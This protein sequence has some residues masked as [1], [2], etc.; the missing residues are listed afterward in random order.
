MFI[1]TVL[2][3]QWNSTYMK[4]LLVCMPGQKQMDKTSLDNWI[5]KIGWPLFHK[6]SYR[7]SEK[8]K[9]YFIAFNW[10]FPVFVLEPTTLI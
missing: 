7:N 2:E 6:Q 9:H 4:D 5:W 1:L 3:E 8:A 10:E